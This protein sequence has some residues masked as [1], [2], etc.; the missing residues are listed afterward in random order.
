MYATPFFKLVFVYAS[1][2]TVSDVSEAETLRYPS[3]LAGDL[4]KIRKHLEEV[5]FIPRGFLIISD[6][7]PGSSFG[8]GEYK[9]NL[10]RA[11]IPDLVSISKCG[12]KRNKVSAEQLALL[13][14]IVFYLGDKNGVAYAGLNGSEQQIAAEPGYETTGGCPNRSH[15]SHGFHPVK[16][17]VAITGAVGVLQPMRKLVPKEL[18]KMKQ[19]HAT[20]CAVA[21]SEGPGTLMLMPVYATFAVKPPRDPQADITTLARLYPEIV[22]PGNTHGGLSNDEKKGCIIHFLTAKRLVI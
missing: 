11:V 21:I 1:N 13:W 4:F 19:E 3:N 14:H 8:G 22:G 9:P 15:G 6:D 10:P 7:D 5:C 20:A 12:A 16:I 18:R 2:D 17:G